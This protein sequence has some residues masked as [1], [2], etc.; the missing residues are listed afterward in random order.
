M[1]LQGWL[2]CVGIHKI[3]S[4]TGQWKKKRTATGISIGC[5]IHLGDKL[6]KGESLSQGAE[7]SPYLDPVSISMVATLQKHWGGRTLW[8]TAL[9]R[10]SGSPFKSA[11]VSICDSNN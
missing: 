6:M 9:Y 4:R 1:G 10:T 7:R 2:R 11:L 5:E 8:L 3:F